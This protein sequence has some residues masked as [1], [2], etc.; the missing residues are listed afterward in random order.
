MLLFVFIDGD[1]DFLLEQVLNCIFWKLF[2][3]FGFWIVFELNFLFLVLLVVLLVLF[4]LWDI[5]EDDFDFII[6][7]MVFF[8]KINN[9]QIFMNNRLFDF[10]MKCFEGMRFCVFCEVLIC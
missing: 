3:F 10:V 4:V 8:V 6:L 1:F 7:L 9:Y 2:M 5:V